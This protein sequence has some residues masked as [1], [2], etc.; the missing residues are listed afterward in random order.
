MR[1]LEGSFTSKSSAQTALGLLSD[2]ILKLS[3]L[4]Q[5]DVLTDWT[6]CYEQYYILHCVTVC[7]ERFNKQLLLHSMLEP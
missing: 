7:Y 5:I 3:R 2:V 4:F 6:L 1:T